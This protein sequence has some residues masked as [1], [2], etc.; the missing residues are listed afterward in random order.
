MSPSEEHERIRSLLGAIVQMTA[1]ECNY[2]IKSIGSTTQCAEMLLHGLEPDASYYLSRRRSKNYREEKKPSAPD[3]AIEVD[4]RHPA[5][6]RARS[7]AKLGVSELWCYRKGVVHFFRL[8]QDGEYRPAN[9]SS[10]LPVLAGTHLTRL[11]K[12]MFETDESS[13]MRAYLRWLRKE[14]KKSSRPSRKKEN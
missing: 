4:L 14:I 12:E 11:V 9:R 7:Y 13:T 5:L 6:G 1:V 3:L 10:L 2:W 8:S